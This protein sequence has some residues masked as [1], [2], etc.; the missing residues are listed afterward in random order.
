MRLWRLLIYLTIIIIVCF[1]TEVRSAKK[2]KKFNLS[3]KPNKAKFKEK[4]EENALNNI[5]LSNPETHTEEEN[6]KEVYNNF[7]GICKGLIKKKGKI[8]IKTFIKS[9]LISKII[10]NIG[11]EQK[12]EI[13]KCCE[14][15]DLNNP[16]SIQKCENISNKLEN[17]IKNNTIFKQLENEIIRKQ[18]RTKRYNIFFK[19]KK[20]IKNILK[21]Y[22]Y[23]C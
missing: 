22:I 11:K 4:R 17:K 10:N 20:M 9:T 7:E 16:Y 18:R 5:P 6:V 14:K 12:E 15:T 23:G 21:K 2:P 1:T 13:K 19:P 8:K 3:L